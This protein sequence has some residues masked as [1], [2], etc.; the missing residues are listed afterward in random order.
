MANFRGFLVGKNL[1]DKTLNSYIKAETYKSTPN[2]RE[3][4]KAYRDENTRNLH[5]V[6]AQGHKTSISFT[7]RRL[8]K[9]EKEIV[10]NYFKTNGNSFNKER[11]IQLYYWND[12][13]N[14]YK[15]AY[16]YLPDI[17]FK[18]KKITDNDIIYDEFEVSLIE[19]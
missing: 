1:T 5:R 13:D 17:E 10:Q 4:I 11:K 3:E 12:E 9:A 6:P 16:F 7:I 8:H 19:Y 18:I 2:A 14:N 15:Q